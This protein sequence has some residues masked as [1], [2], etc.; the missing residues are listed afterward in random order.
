MNGLIAVDVIG[1][2]NEVLQVQL[3]TMTGEVIGSQQRERAQVEERFR[4]DVSRQSAGTI[5]LRAV[6]ATRVQT[7]RLLKIE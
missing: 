3:I 5:L 6:T 4:F 1:T 2:E 7:I